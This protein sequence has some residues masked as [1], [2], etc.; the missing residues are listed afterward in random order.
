MGFDLYGERPTVKEGTVKPKEINWDTATQEEKEI[1]WEAQDNLERLTQVITFVQM[2]GD[3][4][5]FGILYVKC[6]QIY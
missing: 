6:V 1:Y 5:P 2:Y 4:D 3:G